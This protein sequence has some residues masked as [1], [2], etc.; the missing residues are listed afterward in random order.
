MYGEFQ[1]TAIQ[2]MHAVHQKFQADHQLN[3]KRKE[4]DGKSISAQNMLLVENESK[5]SRCDSEVDE[6]CMLCL[7]SRI[8]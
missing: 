4:W 2:H 7:Y 5:R 6:V 3:L 1:V 8:N